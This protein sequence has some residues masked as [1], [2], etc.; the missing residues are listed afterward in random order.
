M[1]K[2]TTPAAVQLSDQASKAYSKLCVAP[3]LLGS[4]CFTLGI[5]IGSFRPSQVIGVLI[6]IGLSLMIGAGLLALIMRFVILPI[7]A[8]IEARKC[9]CAT[10]I[11]K[12]HFL[13]TN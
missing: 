10:C 3:T 1:N 12:R 13:T 7:Q 4:I 11:I 9:Q 6:L 8:W 2:S 5:S